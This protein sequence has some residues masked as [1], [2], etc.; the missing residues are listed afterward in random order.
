MISSIGEE[1]DEDDDKTYNVYRVNI[2]EEKLEVSKFEQSNK[3]GVKAFKPLQPNDELKL[4]K[5]SCHNASGSTPN[6][7]IN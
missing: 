3:L 4:T 7:S 6:K 2:D 5:D 1:K